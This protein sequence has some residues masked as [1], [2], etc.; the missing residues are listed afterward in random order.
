MKATDLIANILKKN[1]IKCA[2]GLQGGAVVHIFDSLIKNKIKVIFT[3][4][5]ESA[6]L[7][8]TANAKLTNEIG[9][10]VVTTG[11]GSTNAITGLLASWQDSVPV[12]FISGQARSNH[13]SYGKKVRQVGTQEV[14][15]CDIIKP[16]TKYSKFI[17]KKE[18]IFKEFNKAILIAKSG[19]PGPVWLDLALDIQWSEIK[20]NKNKIKK[21]SIKK[22]SIKS[23]DIKKAIKLI[24]KSEKPLFVLGYGLRSSNYNIK[25]LKIF[26]D[27]TQIPFVLT[28]NS[29]DLFPTNYSNN[30]G[31]I[32]MS[33]QR[34]ANKAI[35]NS[36]LII[37]IG[38]HLSI[39]HTTTLYES[40]AQNAKKIII[41][42]DNDQLKNLNVNFD[43]KILGNL[44]SFL[45]SVHNKVNV[46]KNNYL[47]NFKS[48]NWYE[49][50]KN[51]Y[52]NSNVFIRKIT[53]AAQEN[54][55]VIID[56]GGTALYAGFQSGYVK[57]KMR[58][59]CSS[60]ISSMGTGLAETIGSHEA[61]LF[62]KFLCIIG[63]GSFL[64]NCQD[65][66]TIF[67]EKIDVVI[68]LVNNNG[69][70]A[71][72]HTQKE[73]LNKRYIGTQAPKDISFPDF[74]DLA[75][76]FKIKHIKLRKN[77]EIENFIKKSST[78]KGPLICEIITS[79][80]QD[81]LFKQGYKKNINNT[82]SP[83]DLSEMYPF[84]E[85]P[86]ANTNN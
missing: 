86:I 47:F 21:I 42:I 25:K 22:K 54:T 69:Y 30:L 58:Y 18:D 63:D 51:G 64:M 55:C 27:K 41:N 60:A 33:G 76:A 52:I 57:S 83:V 59:I 71:I 65:L 7:A 38:T 40:Y 32:G 29:M 19:R 12:I 37:C 66:Q 13:T 72:K 84:V 78:I 8:A 24:N 35:F 82:Y 85:K 28:W 23:N 44:E 15:I 14:N 20:I 10:A 4:H 50:K 75:K 11:P 77:S 48:F 26:F 53:K 16:I 61:N 45:N 81:S 31:I 34:G 62:K 1:S 80:E 43:L 67:Q 70:L 9:C 74:K 2:F 79:D 49:P 3:H 17:S 46:K 36:D 6:A 68:V 73:F 56:G 5:E 39:P